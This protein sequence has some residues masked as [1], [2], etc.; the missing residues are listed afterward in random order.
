MHSRSFP[1]HQPTFFITTINTP[2]V[3]VTDCGALVT[4]LTPFTTAAMPFTE[5]FSDFY[6][7]L[8][9]TEIHAEAP[10][11]EDEEKDD[12]EGGDDGEKEDS[13]EGEE[14]G[15]DEGGD[16]EGGD[17]EEEEEEEE[18][19][20]PKPK[21]EEGVFVISTL[22]CVIDV[23]WHCWGYGRAIGAAVYSLRRLHPNPQDTISLQPPH[24]LPT[25]SCRQIGSGRNTGHT[26]NVG[27][28]LALHV[29]HCTYHAS[30]T[31]HST[32]LS[33]VST[34]LPIPFLIQTPV[35]SSNLAN[36][37]PL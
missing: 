20:D 4:S 25:R 17:D 8:G 31:A 26:V 19:E 23:M 1:Y 12:S 13:G 9:F 28:P 37:L 3:S 34:I 7:S 27:G 29:A 21:L 16:E 30:P 18:P 14:K 36:F 32:A 15:G 35:L 22:D 11:A 24:P 6:A 33:K 10:P 2:L 5:I